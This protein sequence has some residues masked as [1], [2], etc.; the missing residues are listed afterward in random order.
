MLDYAHQLVDSSDPEAVRRGLLLAEQLTQAQPQDWRAWALAG[1]AALVCALWYPD[2]R[3]ELL[4]FSEPRLD[5]ALSLAPADHVARL[6]FYCALVYELQGRLHDALAATLDAVAADSTAIEFHLKHGLLLQDLGRPDEAAQVYKALPDQPLVRYSRSLLQLQTEDY[7]AGWSNYACRWQSEEFLRMARV[8]AWFTRNKLDAEWSGDALGDRTLLVWH[9]QG[10]GDTL[11]GLRF[12][13]LV[14]EQHRNAQIILCVPK[15]LV[16]YVA[17]N[18]PTC[19]VVDDAGARPACDVHVP[20]LNLPAR[21]GVESW[22]PAP[23]H[24]APRPSKLRLDRPAVGIVWAGDSSPINDVARSSPIDA[25]SS[26]WDVGGVTYVSLQVG[27]KAAQGPEQL[28]RP[29]L[30]TFADTAAVMSG[31]DLV[32]GV[33]TAVMHLAGLLGVPAW[34]LLGAAKVDWRFASAASTTPWY[35]TTTVYRNTAGW[36]RLMKDVAVQLNCYL[37]VVH[38][39]N[40]V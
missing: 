7:A 15:P 21:L 5:L 34:L 29:V 33:D 31:L 4:R 6:Y 27:A 28:V 20:M 10:L 23:A 22:V 35:A 18:Y 2:A 14:L 11:W 16:Q 37:E 30:E 13:D 17:H 19:M 3:N 8:P 1:K 26:L 9:E 40:D 39:N 25:W 24:K 12:V 32:I 36:E 38:V